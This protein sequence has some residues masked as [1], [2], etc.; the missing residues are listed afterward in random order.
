MSDKKHPV[1]E[2]EKERIEAL[3]RYSILNT[4]SE[5]QFND[6]TRLVSYICQVP[7]AHVGF[8]DEKRLWFKS[9]V[10][11]E[12]VEMSRE[13][14]FCQHTL[15]GTGLLEV[16]NALESELFKDDA[17]VKGGLNVRFYAGYPLTTPDGYNIGT[18]CAFDTVPK[19]LNEE[20]KN[21]L[22]LL[23]KHIIVQLELGKKNIELDKQTKIAR[24]AV[25][26]KDSFLANM[27]HEIRTPL[28][29]IIG[30]TDLLAQTQLNA[31]QQDYI[32][33][34][35]VAGENLLVIVNDIL[36]LSKIESGKLTI[37][38]HAF[39]LKNALKHVYTLLKI[40]IKPE[41]DFHLYL[42]ADLP[43]MIV[44]DRARLNQILV[45]LVGN[46]IKFTEEG[47]VIIAVKH[48]SE[49]DT[50]HKLKFSVKDTGIGIPQEKLET[51]FERF[52]QA[53]ESTTRRFGGT[54]LGLNIV[55][56]LVELQ[57]GEIGVKSKLGSGS[58]FYFIM[59]MKKA[60]SDVENIEE[61]LPVRISHLK[62]LLCEDNDLNQKLAKNVIENFGFA[63][64]IAD[65]GEE[66][67]ELLKN[68]NYDIVLM[69]LQMPVKDGYQTT[70]YIRKELNSSIPII[71]M[72][73]HSL[74]GEQEKCFQIGM[75]AYITK[76][77]RQAELLEAIK[78]VLDKSKQKPP[79]KQK[80]V[81][82]SYLHEMS[83]G[84]K[85]FMAEM[86]HIFV[87][88]TPAEA[89]SLSEAVRNSDYGTAGKIA[90]S[91]KSSLS[92]FKMEDL[93]ACLDI[94]EHE[95]KD[96]F[97]TP[98][99]AGRLDRLESEINEAIKSIAKAIN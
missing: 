76:P 78:S 48:L 46:A 60:D 74:V 43:E 65:N 83:A 95:A 36:D 5:D 84:D 9:T 34:V 8:M 10:G 92:M 22:S 32:D 3:K 45:N 17:N 68:N 52:T 41:I 23:A 2:N 70:E 26:A 47:E 80:E 53:E 20:Q 27:S 79:V 6:V 62:I 44:G 4:L 66:G 71:A 94:I 99:T 96:N 91:M 50:H 77:F 57:N 13:D 37:D 11:F 72:T 63:I 18:V 88:K 33:S 7:L 21:T 97:F 39:N 19:E 35:Q 24:Q 38:S 61:T 87:S 55:K 98:E 25:R 82:F 56:Q 49:N 29:A 75:D 1:P 58:E 16:P 40:K 30:F 81:D 28:N 93:M 73:A 90:H 67:I 85:G 12:A 42:D 15:M 54:G 31:A 59:E 51:I 69:D 14:T 89:K 64:D 86:A